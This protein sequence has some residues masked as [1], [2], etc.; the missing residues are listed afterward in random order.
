[1]APRTTPKPTFVDSSGTEFLLVFPWNNAPIGSKQDIY[2]DL[3]NLDEFSSAHVNITY[4]TLNENNTSEKNEDYL[5]VPPTNAST[6]FLPKSCVCQ[7][8]TYMT[9]VDQVPSTKIYLVSDIPISVV[10]HNY[11]NGIGDS[12]GVW[13]TTAAKKVYKVSLPSALVSENPTEG[14]ETLY[15]LTETDNNITANVHQKYNSIQF[16]ISLK[17][18]LAADTA[19]LT[20]EPDD[21]IIFVTGTEPFAIVVAVRNLPAIGGQNGTDFGCFMPS[22]FFLRRALKYE[23]IL[24]IQLE[25]K[26]PLQ[27]TQAHTRINEASDFS[28]GL[29]NVIIGDETTRNT[30]THDG[31]PI[32][33]DSYT[34]FK[35][36]K[37]QRY[38]QTI[39]DETQ[40]FH[41]F[42]AE[43][44]Y[45]LY[46]CAAGNGSAASYTPRIQDSDLPL[47]SA[48]LE[49]W[50]PEL[51]LPISRS[52]LANS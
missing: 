14:F 19:V 26:T 11:Y 21:R 24:E 32:D 34:V 51:F 8:R 44:E 35:Y 38:Y 33:S 20:I 29:G 50:S 9:G 6:Y 48:I 4:Y 41:W 25:I 22:S 3:I 43:G 16:S 7:K 31:K 2:L 37:V 12:F 39:S 28:G 10:G 18:D 1:A 45:T 27:F 5:D 49:K 15:F 30:S 36:D 42:S 17:G 13:S 46:I 23:A 47:I 40:G 52:Y